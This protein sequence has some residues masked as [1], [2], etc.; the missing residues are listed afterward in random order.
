M[1]GRVTLLRCSRDGRLLGYTLGRIVALPFPWLNQPL[2]LDGVPGKPLSTFILA[3]DLPQ[4]C[5]KADFRRRFGFQDL[6][7]RS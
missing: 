3:N 4:P 2:A 6:S 7:R 1:C 5:A